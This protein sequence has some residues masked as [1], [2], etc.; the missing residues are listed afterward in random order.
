[1][2]STRAVLGGLVAGVIGALVWAGIAVGLSLEIGWI[3]WA[4][5]G[6]VGFGV[7]LGNRG[8]GG[9]ATGILAVVFSAM[10]ILA[11]KYAA[12]QMTMPDAEE[13]V[14]MYVSNLDNEEFLLSYV[15]DDVARE[16]SAAGRRLN[17]PPGV[18]PENAATQAE[19]P[20]DVWKEAVIRWDGLTKEGKEQF[21]DAREQ[22]LRANVQAA[23]PEIRAA[24]A[25]E[26]FFGSFGGLDL[27]FFG[28]AM[29]TAF[30]IGGAGG[31]TSTSEVQ[32]AFEDAVK[33]VMVRMM[34]ADGVIDDAEI[35]TIIDI[36]GRLSGGEIT[37]E[38]IREEV[39]RIESSDQDLDTTLEEMA[40]YI[41]EHGKELVVKAAIMVAAADGTIDENETRQLGEIAT[42]LQ[43]APAHFQGILAQLTHDE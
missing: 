29:L 12:V 11:G 5:G 30:K 33:Q 23:M 27:L 42:A 4:I 26:G 16:F 37:E 19:Y 8:A 34:L 10:S 7:A 20:A 41:N 1:M 39:D 22:E 14:E 24:A 2:Y 17:W 18:D 38:E 32:V 21:R 36:Y 15:A 40:P 28:L 25:E 3:A 43:M 31:G 6:L 13:I 9:T 35:A